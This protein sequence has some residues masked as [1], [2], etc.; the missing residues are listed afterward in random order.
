MLGEGE[1]VEG[2]E[3]DAGEGQSG[4]AA[5]YDS[6]DFGG[7]QEYGDV[8]DGGVLLHRA[9]GGGAVDSGHHDVHED[10]VGLLGRG[11]GDAFA[12]GAGGEDL[13]ACG[14]LQREGGDLTN[15]IFVVN[16]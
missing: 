4:E 2:V 12:A 6:L 9:E 8:G 14:G 7:E 11:D 16:D 3:E 1:G 15:V 13:P 5:F 10:G